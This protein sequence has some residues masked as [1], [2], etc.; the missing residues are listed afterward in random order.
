MERMLQI[1]KETQSVIEM[2]YMS[3][4]NKVTQR[5]FRVLEIHDSYFVGYCYLRK[6]KRS[7]K[8]ANI[9]SVGPARNHRKGA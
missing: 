4:S 9:L 7:F 3:D 5:L 2:I 8:K 6:G 1:S